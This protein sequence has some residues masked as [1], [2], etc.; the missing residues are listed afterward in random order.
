[1]RTAMAGL[2]IGW[3][4]VF[5]VACGGDD[6]PATPDAAIPDAPPPDAPP[7]DPN[8][9]AVNGS[10]IKLRWYKTQDG[11][12]TFKE[13]FDSQRN[14]VCSA[15]EFSDGKTH[16]APDAERVVYADAGCTQPVGI[17]PDPGCTGAGAPPPPSYFVERVQM[18]CGTQISRVFARGSQLS[19]TEYHQ[20]LATGCDPS[21]TQTTSN[22]IY[23]LIDEVPATALA[24]MTKTTPGA[25]AGRL[26][27]RVWTTPDGL[28][29]PASVYDTELA[30]ECAVTASPTDAAAA[31]CVPTTASRALYRDDVCTQ[32]EAEIATGCSTSGFID[33]ADKPLCRATSHRYF[34]IGSAVPAQDPFILQDTC[35]P[36]VQTPGAS[37]FLPGAEVALPAIARA[38]GT[39][40]RRLEPIYAT[41]GELRV[42]AGLFDIAKVTECV[43]Q[44]DVTTGTIA[45]LPQATAVGLYTDDNC[46]SAVDIALVS[47]GADSCP[48]LPAPSYAVKTIPTQPGECSGGLEPHAVLGLHTGALFQKTLFSCIAINTSGQLTYDVGPAIPLA[49]F[50]ALTVTTDP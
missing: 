35:E 46:T 12:K 30:A 43:I 27:E 16:C 25:A 39:T 1:M 48:A 28:K 15:Q 26:A 40:G 47:T 50:A 5:S 20:K 23:A 32:P 21:P 34:R 17:V 42:R 18:A 13:L 11:L 4:I 2:A 7:P 45:C 49:E 41:V 3:S 19:M 38:H 9:G 31:V 33:V 14:E 29:V 24:V 8:E 22:Q 10:R 37:Y 36:R 6:A 44:N